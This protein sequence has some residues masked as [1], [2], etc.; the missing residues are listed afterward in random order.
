MARR[1]FSPE[2]KRE[3][4]LEA[5]R[6]EAEIPQLLSRYEIRLDM[7]EQWKGKL[8]DMGL[9]ALRYG[10]TSREKA[11]EKVIDRQK[12]IIADQ[13][14]TISILEEVKKHLQKK[15]VLSS[16]DRSFPRGAS[17]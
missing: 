8:F 3:I 5:I 9:E 1:R 2:K 4:V 16:P 6:D 14:M 15:G 17:R 12:K 10:R 13:A 11:L 7:L